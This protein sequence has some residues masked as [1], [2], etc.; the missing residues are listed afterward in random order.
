MTFV[1]ATFDDLIITDFGNV[2]R[3]A[4]KKE[5]F[6]EQAT[7]AEF[8]LSRNEAVQLIH[9]LFDALAPKEAR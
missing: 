6:G 2:L 1:N 8:D 9:K 3:I 4:F 7:L 5:L